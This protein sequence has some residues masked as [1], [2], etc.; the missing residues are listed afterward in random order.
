MKTK[1]LADLFPASATKRQVVSLPELLQQERSGTQ[2]VL[3]LYLNGWA[4]LITNAREYQ[5]TRRKSRDSL[6]ARTAK[7]RSVPE[8]STRAFMQQTR[9]DRE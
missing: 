7:E 4:L 8:G 3:L 1:Y 9:F 5:I 6:R 2:G